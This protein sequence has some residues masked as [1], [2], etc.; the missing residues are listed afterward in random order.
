MAYSEMEGI[1]KP[2]DPHQWKGKAQI[3]KF[4]QDVFS[5][6]DSAG[7]CIFF[8][9]RNLL[10]PELEI[11]PDGILEYLN[12]VTGAEYSLAELMKVGERTLNAERI[13]LL[14]AGFSGKDDA[15]PERLT[16]E[17]FA[18][19]PAKGKVVHLKEMLAEYYEA[20]G[21]TKDG[22]PTEAKQRE[23]GLK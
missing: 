19:G 1:P 18:E 20:R 15:L 4:W 6:I 3:T 2:M 17:P 13:F 9:F 8:A 21:W 14:R 11:Y 10:R 7:L 5:I 12:A 23:L 22:V 16:Q